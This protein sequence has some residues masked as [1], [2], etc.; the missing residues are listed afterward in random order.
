VTTNLTLAGFSFLTTPTGAGSYIK[1]VGPDT[2]TMTSVTPTFNGGFLSLSG[3]GA[4]VNW[5]AGPGPL[6]TITVTP[7]PTTL[8]ISATQQFTAVGTDASGNVVAITPTWSVVASGGTISSTGLFTAGT[9]SGTFTNTVTAT[10][11]AIS[12]TAT[13]MIP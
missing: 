4:V 9:T 8:V 2:L 13:V 10:S 12:G 5:P 6:A 11:G 3:L 7:N 1:V